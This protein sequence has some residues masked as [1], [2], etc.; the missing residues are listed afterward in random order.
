MNGA[1]R[2]RLLRGYG[3]LVA[4]ALLFVLMATFVPTVA[5][6][7]P[8][9]VGDQTDSHHEPSCRSRLAAALI[10]ARCVNACGKLPSSSPVAPISSE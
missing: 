10:S 8:V 3:P 2:T 4:A 5:Q 7:V 9:D 1:P 6:Q